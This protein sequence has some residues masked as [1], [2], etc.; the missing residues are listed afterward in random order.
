M[1]KAKPETLGV[2]LKRFRLEKGWSL[3]KAMKVCKLDRSHISKIEQDHLDG[4]RM[5]TV[6]LLLKAYG[7]TWKDLDS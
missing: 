1:T 2:R 3:S 5:T 6:I 7:K 4:V